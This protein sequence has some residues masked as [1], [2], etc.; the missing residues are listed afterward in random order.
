MQ[1]SLFIKLSPEV[2]QMLLERSTDVS[3][4]ERQEGEGSGLWAAAMSKGKGPF[5]TT[6]QR[7]PQAQTQGTRSPPISQFP[8][9]ISN[10]PAPFL[11]FPPQPL[12]KEAKSSKGSSSAHFSSLCSSPIPTISSYSAQ[13]Q[14]DPPCRPLCRCALRNPKPVPR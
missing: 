8:T 7:H 1:H 11:F 3:Q 5:F 10:H 2:E 6:F 12:R 13:A 14:W 9:V 4:D